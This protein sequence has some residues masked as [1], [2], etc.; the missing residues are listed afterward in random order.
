[1]L[2]VVGVVWIMVRF[3][4][5]RLPGF[6][7]GPDRYRLSGG[8]VAKPVIVVSGLPRSGTS[9]MMNMLAAGGIP[10]LDDQQRTADADNPN[11]YF[12]WERVKKLP[13][14][15]LGWLKDAQGKA[16]KVISA[17]LEHLP[18]GYTYKVI[19]MQRALP[20]IL[21]SQREMLTHNGVD[22]QKSDETALKMEYE[23]HLQR[24]ETWLK[25]QDNF[26]TFYIRYN[27]MIEDPTPVLQKL[28]IFL[29]KGGDLVV[30]EKA[31]RQAVDPALYR[32]RINGS[33]TTH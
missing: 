31:M 3:G 29:E 23:N 22:P 7:L 9:M 26:S 14:G 32:Q 25:Q 11:G 33:R 30:D 1:L 10:I 2:A 18:E 28:K 5:L 27:A 6:S 4:Y 16:V 15:D 8:R 13:Q 17:L 12:E 21:A 19:F 20:E 24:I